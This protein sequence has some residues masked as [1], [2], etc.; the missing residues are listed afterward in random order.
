MSTEQQVIDTLTGFNNVA[1]VVIDHTANEM[2]Q[3][4]NN[5]KYTVKLLDTQP[6]DI[7]N[8]YH[9]LQ[10]DSKADSHAFFNDHNWLMYSDF[11]DSWFGHVTTNKINDLLK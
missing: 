11:G 7:G 9:L 4:I 1:L 6:C 3:L 10:F 5:S 2:Q 8:E